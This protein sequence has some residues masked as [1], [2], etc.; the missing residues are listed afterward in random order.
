MTTAARAKAATEQRQASTRQ[1]LP[2]IFVGLSIGGLFAIE[3]LLSGV[4]AARL[5]LINT[6]RKPCVRLDWIN[7]AMGRLV[8]AGGFPL[9]LDAMLPMLVNPDKLAEMRDARLGSAPYIPASDDDPAYRLMTGGAS[10]NWDVPYEDL[11]VPVLIL[12]GLQD[13]VFRLALF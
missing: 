12:N 4:E 9:L 1:K 7:Q 3:A 5:V 11:S 10:A 6:L 8:A 2:P 13:R